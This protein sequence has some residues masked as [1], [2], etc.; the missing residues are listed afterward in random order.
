MTRDI[1]HWFNTNYKN[2]L[3]QPEALIQQD[4][5]T[6][7]GIDGRKMSKSYNNVIPLYVPQKS[8]RKRIMQVVTDSKE[9]DEP[10]DPESCNLFAIYKLFA[11]EEDVKITHQKYLEGGLGYGHLKQELFELIDA[12]VA[13]GREKYNYYMQNQKLMEDILSE[14]AVKARKIA[15][16]LLSKIRNTIGI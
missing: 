2:I 5:K 6:I 4:V 13:E 14:G 10:K 8:L 1:A 9:V 12:F 3:V 7:P 16:P 15:T 11:K